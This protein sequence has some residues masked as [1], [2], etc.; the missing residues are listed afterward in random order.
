[1]ND[2]RQAAVGQLLRRDVHGNAQR[3]PPGRGF[4]TGR[5]QNPFAELHDET[6]LFRDRNEFARRNISARRMAPPQQHLQSHHL[7]ADSVVLLL[8]KQQELVALQAL[9]HL[10]RQGAARARSFVH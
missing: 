3:V 7:A 10:D 6:R 4:S 8:V 1:V 5:A 2:L 9:A